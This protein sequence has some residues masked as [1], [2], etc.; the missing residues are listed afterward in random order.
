MTVEVPLAPTIFGSSIDAS[1]LYCLSISFEPDFIEEEL[2]L[3]QSLEQ[4]GLLLEADYEGRNHEAL[5]VPDEV[6]GQEY[7]MSPAAVP[8]RA[9]CLSLKVFLPGGDK[10]L[11]DQVLVPDSAQVYA[12]LFCFST[13][14]LKL[15]Q[16]SPPI[17]LLF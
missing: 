13:H 5:G 8:E 7:P 11:Y 16:R 10:D 17:L 12:C 1:G 9:F 15:L 4:T 2:T 3:L 14:L 6:V